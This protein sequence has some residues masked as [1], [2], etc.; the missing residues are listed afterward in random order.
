[1]V[2]Y[3]DYET[4]QKDTV[5]RLIENILQSSDLS[6]E[7][8]KVMNKFY[9]YANMKGLRLRSIKSYLQSLKLLFRDMDNVL[10]PKQKD[11]DKYLVKIDREYKPKT[12]TE[13]R[14]FLITFYQWYYNKKKSQIPLIANLNV[15]KEKGTKLPDE[16]LTADEIKKLCQIADNFRDKALLILLYETAARKGEFLKLKIKHIQITEINTKKVGFVTIPMGKTDS[17]KLPIIYSVPHLIN[18]LNS[19]PSRDDPNAPLFITTKSYQGRALGEDGLKMLVKK[20]GVRAEIKKTIFPHLFRHSRLTELAKELT[21]QEL[22]IYAGWTPDSNMASTYVHLAGNDVSDKIL[23]NAGLIDSKNIHKS[24]LVLTQV[25]CPTCNRENA[26]DVKICP[27][28]R[29]LDLK[30]AQ[31]EIDSLKTLKDEINELKEQL[32]AEITKSLPSL[33]MKEVLKK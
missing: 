8:K 26:S 10:N 31:K 4:I 9:S 19:H 33:S 13:R 12:V 3:S 24:K 11:L 14:K 29:V 27:C 22:K 17:R 15:K 23:A 6:K 20:Y 32:I 1:M 18:W 30:E 7:Q 5:N 21:E 25:I 16:L 2:K 28:G